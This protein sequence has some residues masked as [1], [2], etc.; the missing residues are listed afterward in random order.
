MMFKR[1]VTSITLISLIT[2]LCG[3]YAN[4][5]ISTKQVELYWDDYT[6]TKIVTIDGGV[7]EFLDTPCSPVVIDD[8]IM[9]W[10]EG[11]VLKSIPLE[12][13]ETI[14]MTKQKKVIAGI[15]VVN[16]ALVILAYFLYH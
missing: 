13:V 14:Y 7:I 9:G 2:C 3:C 16:I 4:K 6:I 11:P 12:Q 8:A 15:L 10:I 1:I 5:R